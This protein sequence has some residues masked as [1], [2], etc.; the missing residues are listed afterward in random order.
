MFITCTVATFV[1]FLHKLFDRFSPLFMI[2]AQYV[3]NNPSGTTPTSDRL[4]DLLR[5]MSKHATGSYFALNEFD[6]AWKAFF[7]SIEKE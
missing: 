6:A 4:T 7:Q 2:I 3:I 5:K 1:L